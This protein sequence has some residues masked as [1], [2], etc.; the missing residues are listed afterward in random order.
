MENNIKIMSV[1]IKY[2][3][4]KN[5]NFSSNLV[6]FANDKFNIAN[7]KKFLKNSEFSY[8]NDLLKSSDSKKNLLVFEVNSKKKIVLVSIKNNLK[9]SDIESLG[10]EFYGRVNYGK[11][12]EYLLNT[13]SV[14]GKYD[15][16][17]GHFLHGL[18]LKSYEFKKYKTKKDSRII[19]INIVGNKNKPST[20]NQLKF[21]A[22]EEGTFFARDLVS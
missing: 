12:S 13:D 2:S 9:S 5:N 10:A 20:Q 3:K 18:K 8:I 14:T 15:N 19:T 4:I 17:V 21:K 11:N 16:F 6:L 7:L 22:L 1:N